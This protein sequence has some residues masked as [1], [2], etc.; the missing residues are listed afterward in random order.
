[1]LSFMK[2]HNVNIGF[3]LDGP[4]D[5]HN[6]YR[7]D[8]FDMVMNSIELYHSIY[9]RYPS[10]NCTVG[11]DALENTGE[12]ITFFEQFKSRITFSR[13]IGRLGITLEQY[14][15]FMDV[16]KDKLNVRTGGYDCTMYGG[17][18]GAGINN[19][20]YS[21]RRIYM[22]GNC[23]DLES[24]PYDTPID[25]VDFSVESFDRHCCYKEMIRT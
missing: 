2:E 1:M 3:S 23:I 9:D 11:K 7:C 16:V 22:C 18:C 19:I 8:T 5:I 10:L 14:R 20:F 12:I 25:E 13:M 15:K 6:K 21:N 24:F 17:M 4:R